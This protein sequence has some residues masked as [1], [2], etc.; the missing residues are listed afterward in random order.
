MTALLQP[1]EVCILLS[2]IKYSAVNSLTFFFF[3]LVET[4]LW[5]TWF[6][7]AI[8]YRVFFIAPSKERFNIFPA[9][10][11]LPLFQFSVSPANGWGMTSGKAV[12]EPH[13]GSRAAAG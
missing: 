3:F 10:C 9:Q 6:I 2:M 4:Y 1:A 5:I 7:G 12:S 11:V 13:D 8:V